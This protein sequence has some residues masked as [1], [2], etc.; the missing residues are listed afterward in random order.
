MP[1]AATEGRWRIELLSGAAQVLHDRPWPVPAVPTIWILEVDRPAIVLGST[2]PD[3]TVD[4]G[5]LDAAGIDL[6]RRRSGGGAVLLVPGGALW[7]DVLVPTGDPLWRADVGVAFE[8]VGDRWC[9]ALGASG[10]DA[11]AHRGPLVS[12]RWSARLCFAGLGPGEV[13]VGGRKA[14]G[15]SQRRTR[16]GALFQCLAVVRDDGAELPTLLDLD[17]GERAQARQVL[18]ARAAALGLAP[19]ALAGAFVRAVGT[20]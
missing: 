15:I 14:V 19:G 4:A 2:Q 5:R 11:V 20:V 9:A 3:D 1:A 16:A 7:I 13:T 6:V 8:W 10:I 17:D 18:T 12:N